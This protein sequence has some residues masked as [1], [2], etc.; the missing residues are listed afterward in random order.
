MTTKRRVLVAIICAFA[1]LTNVV[2][3][4]AQE[5]RTRSEVVTN[6]VFVGDPGQV[7][8]AGAQG[9]NTFLFVSSEMSIDGKLVKGAPY[10][11][12]A[13]NESVQTLVG[14]NRIVRQNTST[15]PP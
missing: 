7:A 2:G 14:G 1:V 4:G 13:V 10:S 9:D 12:Q 3:I 11:A 5:K 6:D 15:I 8:V